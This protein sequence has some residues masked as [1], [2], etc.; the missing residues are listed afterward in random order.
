MG[1]GFGIFPAL[2]L[3]HL[4]PAGRVQPDYFVRL[5]R[6]HAFSHGVLNFLLAGD[7][8]PGSSVLR[9][10]VRLLLHGLKNGRFSLRCQCAARSGY[11]DAARFI[12]RHRLHPL[13]EGVLALPA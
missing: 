4:I 2:R 7:A 11:R 5:I 10:G 13:P 3:T 6:G 12:V 9:D 1:M 8:P